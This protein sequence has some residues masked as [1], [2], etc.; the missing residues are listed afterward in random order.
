MCRESQI[1]HQWPQ[2][3]KNKVSFLYEHMVNLM[4]W[5]NQQDLIYSIFSRLTQTNIFLVWN[6]KLTNFYKLNIKFDA[7]GANL[8]L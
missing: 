2:K 1:L 3:T 7:G 6:R 8:T 5:I 4:L